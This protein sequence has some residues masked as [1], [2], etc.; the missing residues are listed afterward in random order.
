MA[1]S[2]RPGERQT[3]LGGQNGGTQATLAA[4]ES[5]SRPC[6]AHCTCLK[7]HS[8]IQDQEQT[9]GAGVWPGLGTA[10]WPRRESLRTCRVLTHECRMNTHEKKNEMYLLFSESG[11]NK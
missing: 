10:C 1:R 9:P 8:D 11:K 6:R 7:P 2:L 3:S 4:V 5:S